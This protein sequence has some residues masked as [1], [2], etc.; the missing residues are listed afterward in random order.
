[1]CPILHDSVATPFLLF[2]YFQVQ[3]WL[4]GVCVWLAFTGDYQIYKNPGCCRRVS[5]GVFFNHS[6]GDVYKSRILHFI[7]FKMVVNLLSTHFCNY[8]K[9][10]SLVST[11]FG[12]IP[13]DVKAEI[14]QYSD[15][16]VPLRIIFLCHSLD[17]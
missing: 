15:V 12:Y 2:S 16:N 8:L 3:T 4:S 1:M 17:W 14:R 13:P 7:H 11:F 6:S 5:I 10:F 9:K